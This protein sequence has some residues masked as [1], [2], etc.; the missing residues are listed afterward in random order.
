MMPQAWIQNHPWLT[1]D[2]YPNELIIS[3][4]AGKFYA[5]YRLCLSVIFLGTCIYDN[6][7]CHLN[8]E[9]TMVVIFKKGGQMIATRNP[10]ERYPKHGL[11][12]CFWK[13]LQ[14]CIFGNATLS[15]EENST[16]SQLEQVVSSWIVN[17]KQIIKHVGSLKIVFSH[18]LYET[19]DNYVPIFSKQWSK[20]P[21]ELLVLV[22]RKVLVTSH[23]LCYKFY[24]RLYHVTQ[25]FPSDILC[26][27]C[28]FSAGS[29]CSFRFSGVTHG[30]SPITM[31]N[32]W[33]PTLCHDW[34]AQ[35]HKLIQYGFSL[36]DGSYGYRDFFEQNHAKFESF[37]T[38]EQFMAH[39]NQ[40]FL[41]HGKGH[42]MGLLKNLMACLNS[43]ATLTKEADSGKNSN[44]CRGATL[45]K[46]IETIQRGVDTQIFFWQDK[47]QE[48]T[49]RLGC[50]LV[51]WSGRSINIRT[52]RSGTKISSMSGNQKKIIILRELFQFD[53][54]L[55]DV[56][57]TVE[58]WFKVMF[59][60]FNCEVV[61]GLIFNMPVVTYNAM[62]F[63]IGIDN[64]THLN[65]AKPSL[66]LSL[67]L[68][69]YSL[70]QIYSTVIPALKSGERMSPF[71]DPLQFIWEGDVKLCYSSELS[72]QPMP[73]GAPLIYTRQ[74]NDLLRRNGPHPNRTGEFKIVFSIIK[75]Y[76]RIF[77]V[78]MVFSQ[79]SVHGP[80]VA[81]NKA[82]DLLIVYRKKKQIKLYFAAF[83][84]HHSFTH[85]CPICPPLLQYA[86]K[87]SYQETKEHSDKVDLFWES[88]CRGVFKC[89]LEVIYF[90]HEFTLNS[91]TYKDIHDVPDPFKMLPSDLLNSRN[92]S[93]N[94]LHQ[95]ID[96]PALILIVIGEGQQT[97]QCNS[98]DAAIFV[99]R[100]GITVMT[101]RNTTPTIFTSRH[102]RFL[103]REKGFRFSTIYHVLVFQST[104][105]FGSICNRVQ[106]V[107]SS[108]PNKVLKF[109]LNSM[110]G[111]FGSF[112]EVRSSTRLIQ[113]MA[114]EK[115]WHSRYQ[116]TSTNYPDIFRVVRSSDNSCPT[117]FMYVMH[118][119]IL[120]SYRT[121]M[122][123]MLNKCY[124][125]FQ[126]KA[127]RLL[128]IKADSI[129]LG[130]STPS[131]VEASKH[132][133]C[134]FLKQWGCAV[135]K[136][137][138]TPGKF[139]TTF[140]TDDLPT[141][142]FSVVF[143]TVTAVQFSSASDQEHEIL[144]KHMMAH[145][146]NDRRRVICIYDNNLLLT[147]PF[148]S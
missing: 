137:G 4:I 132:P 84:V 51:A 65:L 97:R 33:Y 101:T 16:L 47:T 77:D 35:Q 9:G 88:Y 144:K 58:T 43:M 17:H 119:V 86:Q 60:K 75:T 74:D 31:L 141:A 45:T 98:D 66:A 6:E 114:H 70:H 11:N 82:I 110:I 53:V 23:I 92:L 20:S 64:P 117:T 52:S 54:L 148:N 19:K 109:A 49:H 12:N 93:I 123:E 29:L 90:C 41:T 121:T 85:T 71:H 68:K 142:D 108:M 57:S 147:V 18:K 113:K 136:K 140:T 42:K 124:S 15:N 72:K 27:C 128:R 127:C 32:Q 103:I 135:P 62:L 102:L 87:K 69:K 14:K 80:F 83:Q 143:P 126:S 34:I 95:L 2:G 89:R 22:E 61:S 13:P 111:L 107:Q 28:G 115:S 63:Q 118:I 24:K 46:W 55:H 100:D 26:K 67:L 40:R 10:R 50:E 37:S 129:M 91:T 122:V 38:I 104:T 5:K 76:Q 3:D 138:K 134:E 94:R 21:R 1:E 125:L 130:F 99:K 139:R 112:R 145:M 25:V 59:Q 79:Y 105:A 96:D 8:S 30:A 146:Q 48:D 39:A 78:I 7:L 133:A 73:M 56:T 81:A 36:H 131:L 116:Y 120:S 106:S 44:R